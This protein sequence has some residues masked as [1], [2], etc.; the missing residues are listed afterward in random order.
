MPN[1]IAPTILTE[2]DI[3]LYIVIT[4]FSE[5]IITINVDIAEIRKLSMVVM[6][7]TQ[8]KIFESTVTI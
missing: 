6:K 4:A 5:N 1:R 7:N 3:R 2:K 8:N